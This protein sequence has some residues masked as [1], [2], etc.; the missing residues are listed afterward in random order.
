[1]RAA[2]NGDPLSPVT[3][4]VPSDLAGIAARRFLAQG[5]DGRPGIAAIY[6]TTLKRLA[7]ELAAPVLHPRRPATAPVLAAA[8]RRALKAPGVF[9]PVAEHPATVEA[10]VRAGVQLRDVD[11][12]GRRAVGAA[13][14]LG[15]DLV[16][17]MGDV[18]SGLGAEWYDET[19]L[20]RTAT[21][22]CL[23]RPTRVVAIGA[24]VLY[25][26]QALTR[27]EADF[28]RALS[29]GGRLRV[30]AGLTGVAR[31]DDAVRRSLQQVGV[32]VPPAPATPTAHRVIT[33]SDADDEV[34]CVV[35]EVVAALSRDDE[36][37]GQ[38]EGETDEPK[39]AGHRVAVLYTA[40][41][42]YARLLQ[43]HLGAA[44]IAVNGPGTRPVHER[45]VPRA[46]VEL[47]DLAGNEVPRADLFRVLSAAP[48]WF[49]GDR[50]PVTRWE[51]ISRAAGV[52][53]GDD[54]DRHLTRYV[55]EHHAQ[56]ERDAGDEARRPS[57]ERRE[58]DARAADALRRFVADLRGELHRG[59][60]LVE[61]RELSAWA[62]DLSHSLLGDRDALTR[63]PKEEQDAAAALQRALRAVAVLDEFGAPADLGAL[64]ETITSQL[65]RE[66]PRNGRFGTGVLVAPVSA[67]VGLDADVVY[68]V[69]LAEALYPGRFREDP[70][71]PEEARLATGGQLLGQREQV[72]AAHRH[73][74]A[75][76][77]AAPEVV[78]S[79]PRG[80]LR[81]SREH[82]PSRF[83]LPTLRALAG[84]P[85]L[86]ATDWA[87]AQ[88]PGVWTSPSFAGSLT[89]TRQP[90]S[91][92]EW[93]TAAVHAGHGPIGDPVLA[94]ARELVDARRSDRFTRFDGNLASVASA[95]PGFFDADRVVSP[96][97]LEA[98]VA[99]P[100]GYFVER[101]LGVRPVEQPEDLLTVSAREVG[102]LIHGAF[103]ALVKAFPD[104]LP[105][106]GRPWSREQRDRLRDIAAGLAATLA[107]DGRTG[108]R[109]LWQ[110][111]LA[112]I[113]D[114]LQAMLDD[115][116]AWRA[117]NQAAV[118]ASEMPFGM[119]GAA[120]VAIALPDGTTLL[121]RG[122]ADKVDR[123]ADGRL[124]VSDIKSGS[125]KPFK[126]L[127]ARDPVLGGSKLQLPV[128][129]HAVRQVHGDRDTV[130]EAGYWFVGKE[131]RRI[132]VPLT[133]A[134]ETRYA[135]TLLT[136]VTSIRAG[137]F[138]LRPPAAADRTHV[139]CWYCNPDGIGHVQTR[140]RWERLKT[141]PLLAD[142]VALVEPLPPAPAAP[143][144]TDGAD[145]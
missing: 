125:S 98:Y 43:E 64:R 84:R 110:K 34:R 96:T 11:D 40:R 131:R 5:L 127:G 85:E 27:A 112:G 92:Q 39:Q 134:V 114:D 1:M 8:W 42:P 54:W 57:A 30:V 91:E 103:D 14:A 140:R 94:A 138:P 53:Q 46:F 59:R 135:E 107:A 69:G 120:P 105:G 142:L 113:Q 88:I 49:E 102:T 33:A 31:A 116:D 133:E 126:G 15:P 108:H 2:K 132:D 101:L 47:L 62:L 95:F 83:L 61:W 4:V 137:L 124:V 78:A 106:H 119:H 18:E 20:L 89:T 37:E 65:E 117:D 70:L 123:T 86:A 121:M 100:H 17:L 79:F 25:L 38:A 63:L 129:A 19:D 144:D 81:A 97:S 12:A 76:F 7:E 82:L 51:R 128:Y 130:V 68:V 136:I 109:R 13:T 104:S 143:T 90:A 141:D 44:G 3:I 67:A 41:D 50:V 99:C 48:V 26:P 24:V 23:D 29:A 32:D 16:R 122:S 6:P 111:A 58:S 77:A 60:R 93:R 80:D 145:A 52:V 75:A 87:K 56:A 45:A 73:L 21:T 55:E 35:R 10:L 36:A 71:L 118:I 28:V 74:L 66:V 9:E 115:D 22:L 72:D 139:Q